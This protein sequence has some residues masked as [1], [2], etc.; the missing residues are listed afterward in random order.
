MERRVDLEISKLI[1]EPIN[2]Q[3]PVPVELRE[4][5][6]VDT[7]EP[8]EKL[9]RYTN[10]DADLDTILVVDT[11]DGKLIHVKRSP[12]GDT[13]IS[14]QGLNSKK[15]YVLV[16]AVL[17]SPDTKILG[18]KKEAIVRGMDK[19]ELKL[20]LDGIEA[21]TNTPGNA[22]VQSYTLASGDDLYDAIM[23]M[24]HLVEDYGDDYVLLVGSAVKEAIDT[25]DKDNASS[26]NYNVTL[27]A[28]LRELGIKPM[29]I[30]GK[31]ESTD[32][33]G[34]QVLL[35]TKHMI[36]LARNSRVAEGKPIWFVRRKISPEIARLMGADVD[37]AQRALMVGQTP[38][39]VDFSGTSSNVLGFSVVGY[40]SVIFA[41]PN[42]KMI[43]K[44]DATSIV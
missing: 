23:G 35:N 7:V 27:T 42:P 1:G 37:V 6:N 34:E 3:L 9:W 5:C 44:C 10:V 40:E 39:V 21:D 14:F 2:Y 11:T 38:E 4:V 8:G 29:K 43:V 30:F 25:Y 36:L 24:K 26:F 41:I 12:L 13:E 18:R 15:E 16:D 20:V 19:R 33:G 28:K 22:N 17:A 31:V 32:G